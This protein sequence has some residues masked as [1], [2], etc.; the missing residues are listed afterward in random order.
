MWAVV[1]VG[2]VPPPANCVEWRSS[3]SAGMFAFL[4]PHFESPGVWL[5]AVVFARPWCASGAVEGVEHTLETGQPDNAQSLSDPASDA[6]FDAF[7][8][9]ERKLSGAIVSDMRTPAGQHTRV[10]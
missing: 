10:L 2:R 6:S 9:L 4:K 7:L 1:H 8:A 3:L 5:P